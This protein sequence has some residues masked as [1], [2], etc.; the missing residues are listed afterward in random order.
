M[1]KVIVQFGGEE[2]SVDLRE[3]V[4]VAGRS[5][6]ASIPIRDASMSR[7]HCDIVLEAGI[8][9]VVD[10]GSM[11]GTLVNGTKMDR[12]VL[13]PGDKIQI[14][15]AALYFEEKRG[16]G[17]AVKA[18]PAAAATVVGMDDFS[19]W[20]RESGGAMKAVIGLVILAAL[21]VGAVF[22][23]K[24]L[25]GG[26]TVAV[27]PGNLLGRMGW[28][29]PGPD[30]AVVGWAMKRG[31]AS[32]MQI[33]E[34]GAKQGKSCLQLE[35]SGAA[36]DLVVEVVYQETLPAAASSAVEFSA[37]VRSDSPGILPALKATWMASRNG[38][39]LLEDM[40]EPAPGSSD[41]SQLT[42]TFLPPPGATNV[43]LSLIAAGR[44]GRILFD[45]A[46][47][48]IKAGSP[49]E[50]VSMG[51]YSVT[52]TQAGALTIA[53]DTRRLISNAQLFL[54]SDKEG[55]ISQA[56]ATGARVQRDDAA[57]KVT[58][59]GKLPSPV[60]LR[61][62]DFE[63]EASGGK[64]SLVI[65]YRLRGDSLK[66]VDRLGVTLLLP[67]SDLKGDYANPVSRLWFRSGTGDSTLEISDGLMRV[68]FDWAPGGGQRVI[69]MVPIPKGVAEMAFGFLLK[70]GGGGMSDPMTEVGKAMND[71]R[72]SDAQDLLK[73]LQAATREEAKLSDIRNRLRTLDE[74][75]SVDWQAAQAQRFVAELLG[76]K[77]YYE[78][79]IQKLDQYEKRWPRGRRT[80]AAKA[81]RAKL[82]AGLGAAAE[83]K[84]TV[85]AHRLLDRAEEHAKEG[86]KQLARELCETVKRHY[87]QSAS[88]VAR[89]SE[90]LKKMGSE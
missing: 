54:A 85:R 23:F 76:L 49:I 29:E 47:A 42:R 72:M 12:K 45:D 28:M 39:V 25:K 80:E 82:T 73:D 58:A 1:P 5:P 14:G 30:K 51:G 43:Q 3:G 78:S 27:D 70:S 75:E 60:D 68:S 55:T 22:F 11:N 62:V 69:L 33:V 64:D 86:R 74:A 34:G 32:R 4:N 36:G 83:D 15:K 9:T 50:S 41:W 24:S 38:S 16:G 13:A 57:K 8:A 7:E 71:G 56:A 65:G 66:Q 40:S 52:S 46:R 6:Q 48:T 37:W 26:T 61:P 84:E 63:I 44:G 10:R 67:G 88:A 19:V 87:A 77:P 79:A 2:W 35:K 53:Q 59:A 31:L 20:R 81:E 17:T 21:G 90:L 18:A 89:A